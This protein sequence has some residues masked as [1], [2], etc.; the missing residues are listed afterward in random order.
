M[1]V[2]TTPVLPAAIPQHFFTSTEANPPH[3]RLQRGSVVVGQREGVVAV[4]WNEEKFCPSWLAVS[5]VRR[6]VYEPDGFNPASRQGNSRGA[7]VGIACREAIP[8]GT[9]F[10]P[11]CRQPV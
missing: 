9:P 3:A 7:R 2:I 4:R 5:D 10:D 1:C 11:A 6:V 8:K